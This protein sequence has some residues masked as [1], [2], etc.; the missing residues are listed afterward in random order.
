M[1]FLHL[2]FVMFFFSR[3]IFQYLI[4]DLIYLVLN[5]Q[6]AGLSVNFNI[7]TQFQFKAFVS[8]RSTK[9]NHHFKHESVHYSD[10]LNSYIVFTHKVPYVPLK[11]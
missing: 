10:F 9:F 8:D 3:R 4:P 6:K 2:I 1:T 7:L 11:I 5:K